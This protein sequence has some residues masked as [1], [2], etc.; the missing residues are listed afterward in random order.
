MFTSVDSAWL[1]S[2]GDSGSDT[3][4]DVFDSTQ[5]V[6]SFGSSDFELVDDTDM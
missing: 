6:T 2:G 1:S 4:S 3:L 5:T